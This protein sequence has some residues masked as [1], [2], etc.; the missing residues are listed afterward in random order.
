[1]TGAP[2]YCASAGEIPLFLAP[3]EGL[4]D[5]PFRQVRHASAS[6]CRRT[7]CAARSHHAPPSF[8]PHPLAAHSPPCSP[9]AIAE[10]SG[11]FT[12]SYTEFIRVPGVLPTNARAERYIPKLVAGFGY[13]RREL[14]DVPL[15]AQARRVASLPSLEHARVWVV[16]R[17]ERAA[18]AT[19]S[20][21]TCVRRR[22]RPSAVSAHACLGEAA[23]PVV[24]RLA[25]GPASARQQRAALASLSRSSHPAS[26]FLGARRSWART[27]T[28]SQRP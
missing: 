3:M 11:G 19:S 15:A 16:G 12:E 21:S 2:P 18:S 22:L 20:V 14:G 7:A 8:P 9:Q 28:C 17:A 5:R 6:G 23:A 27:R 4:A 10:C 26:F 1:M 24:T 13:D 25:S